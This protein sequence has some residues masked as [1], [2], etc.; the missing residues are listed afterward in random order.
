MA[1]TRP[2]GGDDLTENWESDNASAQTSKKRKHDSQT[3]PQPAAAAAAASTAKKAKQSTATAPK[4]PAKQPAAAS[5]T[6]QRPLCFLSAEEQA[7]G[8]WQLYLQSKCGKLLS[9]IEQS[10]HNLT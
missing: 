5:S 4:Q 1:A 3:T 7:S 2:G 9:S 8:F 6:S 10:A